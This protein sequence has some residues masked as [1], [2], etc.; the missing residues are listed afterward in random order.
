MRKILI[1]GVA[2]VFSFVAVAANSVKLKDDRPDFY[3]VKK[4]DTLW[5]I[6]SKYLNSPW[7]WPEIWHANPQVENPHLIYPG[8][9][10]K[11]VYIDGQSKVMVVRGDGTVKLSPDVRISALD[12]AIPAIPLEKINAFLTQSRILDNDILSGAPYVDRKSVV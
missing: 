10:L 11:L 8:D 1:L 6:S 4:G 5:D 12:V 7:L 2:L 3:F 9:Q